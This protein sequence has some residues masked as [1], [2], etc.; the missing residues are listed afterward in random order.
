MEMNL[1]FVPYFGYGSSGILE[2][3]LLWLLALAVFF[4]DELEFC[5]TWNGCP[6][7]CGG[8]EMPL[9]LFV[10]TLWMLMLGWGY[11]WKANGNWNAVDAILAGLV[12][13]ALVYLPNLLQVVSPL[14]EDCS[15][16]WMM[17]MMV[18]PVV[19]WKNFSV[20]GV[21]TVWA[22]KPWLCCLLMLLEMLMHVLVASGN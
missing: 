5:C 10:T 18:C 20:A 17:L 8:A 1:G 19:D 3:P 2:T 16:G 22:T 13:S 6:A 7:A 4:L 11:C 21:S 14:C 9:L 12:L 15:G